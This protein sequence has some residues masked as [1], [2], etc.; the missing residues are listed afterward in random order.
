MDLCHLS[1]PAWG[2]RGTYLMGWLRSLG[3]DRNCVL[4]D[5]ARRGRVSEREFRGNV[6]HDR[7]VVFSERGLRDVSR[8]LNTESHALVA[9]HDRQLR[10]DVH[11]QVGSIP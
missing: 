2:R 6:E 7:V 5:G 8:R 1:F 11:H 3:P 9:E 4:Y 10:S